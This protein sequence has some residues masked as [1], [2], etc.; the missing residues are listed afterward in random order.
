MKNEKNELELK[1]L[2]REEFFTL[3]ELEA[4][5]VFSKLEA[6]IM[7]NGTGLPNEKIVYVFEDNIVLK[8]WATN[9]KTEEIIKKVLD[10]LPSVQLQEHDDHKWA[11]QKI[12]Q[13]SE[14]IIRDLEAL[15]KRT[16]L[17]LLSRELQKLATIDAPLIEGPVFDPAFLFSHSN[18]RGHLLPL[19]SNLWLPNF[20]WLGWNDSISSVFVVSGLLLLCEHSWWSGRSV[21]LFPRPDLEIHNLEAFGLND[22][23]SSALHLHL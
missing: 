6:P 3:K 15:S 2:F 8:A 13:K 21:W 7:L 20:N 10:T 9:T 22:N 23:V 16:E 19:W 14:R 1:F 12:T 17:P 18:A 5:E 4:N 11:K